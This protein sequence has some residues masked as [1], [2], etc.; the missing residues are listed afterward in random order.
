VKLLRPMVTGYVAERADLLKYA[1]E[2]FELVTSGKVKVKI[3]E[4]YPLGDV[5][6]AHADL[7]SRKTT[8]K[9]ILRC[10]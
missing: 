10:D 5:A 9:L 8:G 2:L 3:H 4:V 7:E 1:G 6:R